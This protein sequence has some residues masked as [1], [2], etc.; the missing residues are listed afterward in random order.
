MHM[1]EPIAGQ[2]ISD[3]NRRRGEPITIVVDGEPVRA[4]RGETVAAAMLAAGRRVLRRTVRRGAPRGM[5]CGMGVCFECQTTID[6]ANGVRSCMTA[7]REGM[8]I[9]TGSIDDS[10]TR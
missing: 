7:V 1:S 5:F 4:H 10:G 3:A 2:R 6:G 9:E 8:R